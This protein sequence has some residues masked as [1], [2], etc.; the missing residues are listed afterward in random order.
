VHSTVWQGM[1]SL[2]ENV[3]LAFRDE[4]VPIREWLPILEAAFANF[5]VG[6]I[7]PALD[8]VLVGTVD[9]SRDSDIKLA[10]VLGLNETVFPALPKTGSLLTETDR[11]ELER[12]N[13]LSSASVRLQLGRERF[14]AYLACTRPREQLLLTYAREDSEGGPL[15][16][17]PFVAH[18]QKL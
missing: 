9:R 4:T 5:S 16:P 2:T 15:N 17:S 11:A 13:T 6:I 8:Q 1:T 12:Q 14:Y 7:P 18:V 3:E 10:L